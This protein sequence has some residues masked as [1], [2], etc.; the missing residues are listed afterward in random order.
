MSIFLT[1]TIVQSLER[2]HHIVR[3]HLLTMDR[4]KCLTV[5]DV[6]EWCME[7]LEEEGHDSCTHC[8]SNDFSYDCVSWE[9]CCRRCGVVS[10][11]EVDF[12]IDYTRPSTYFKH[13]YFTNTIL[14]NAMHKGFK[15]SRFQMVEMERRFKLCVDK[16]NR[17]KDVHKRKYML[18]SNFVLWKISLS[19]ELHVLPFLKMPKKNTQAKL[20]TLWPL[21]NPF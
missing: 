16:F 4:C 3:H 20:E 5:K 8:G 2:L 18:N 14:T 13:N 7:P 11:Y 9:S 10:S 19:L 15:I 6:C 12:L 17:S 1:I 21:V